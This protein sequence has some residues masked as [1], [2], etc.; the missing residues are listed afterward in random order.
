MIGGTEE[1]ILAHDAVLSAAGRE[2]GSLVGRTEVIGDGGGR[3]RGDDG[4]DGEELHFDGGGVEVVLFGRS[5]L[6][7]CSR[8]VA[9]SEL[10]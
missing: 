3:G 6:E 4:G 10:C 8:S 9:E 5:L 7:W 1:D 2:V